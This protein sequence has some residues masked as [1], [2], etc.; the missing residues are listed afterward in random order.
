MEQT[1]PEQPSSSTTAPTTT[2]S[3]G[4]PQTPEEK[5]KVAQQLKE[6]GNAFF[7]QQEYKKALGKYK[8]VC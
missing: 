5:I 7:K 8:Y 6:E 2:S 4:M 3:Q 1:Q